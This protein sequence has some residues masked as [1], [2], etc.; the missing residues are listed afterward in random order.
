MKP[1][2]VG[3]V[4]GRFQPFHKGH[5]YLIKKALDSAEN[6]VIGIGSSNVKN[7][8]N[9]YSFSK[10]KEM[11]ELFLEKEHLAKKVI[12]I[13]PSPDIPNDDKWREDVLKRAG[14]FDVVIG[15]NDWVNGIFTKVGIPVLLV[16]YYKR[17]ILEGQKIRKLMRDGKKWE[18]RVP[19]YL[20]HS[21]RS[22]PIV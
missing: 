14:K 8:D 18:E 7:N 12:A 6:L 21:I 10:R 2:T 9:P 11:L 17:D 4:V 15:N 13:F 22:A 19:K 3:L 20:L 1:Y 16:N 5:K